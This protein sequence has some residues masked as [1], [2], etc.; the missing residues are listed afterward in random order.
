MRIGFVILASVFLL[1]AVTH[2]QVGDFNGDSIYDCH[3]MELLQAVK[4]AGSN[5][6]RFDLSGDGSVDDRDIDSWLVEANS[7]LG[8]EIYL[9]DVDMDGDVDHRDFNTMAVNHFIRV[10]V[11]TVVSGWCR[12]DYDGDGIVNSAD[13]NEIGSNWLKGVPWDRD[14]PE[15]GNLDRGT[16]VVELPVLPSSLEAWSGDGIV[17]ARTA[18]FDLVAISQRSPRGVLATNVIARMRNDTDEFVS[19]DNVR[20]SGDVHQAWLSVPFGLSQPT[21]KG[22]PVPG[23]AYH[24]DWIRYDSHVLISPSEAGS[25]AGHGYDGIDEINDG[26]DP[27]DQ[28]GALPAASGFPPFLGIGEISS[29]RVTDIFYVV[30]DRPINNLG[31]A[32]AVTPAEI[33]LSGE[34]GEVFLTIGLQGANEEYLPLPD[35]GVVDSVPVPFF[36]RPCDFDRN[37]AC[38]VNELNA[39]IAAIGSDD[40][41]YNL[42]ANPRVNS[43]DVD[44]WL[45]FAGRVD[46]AIVRGDTDLDGDVDASDLNHL[47]L[48]WLIPGEFGWAGGDFDGNGNADSADLNVIGLNWQHGK[49]LVA[50]A[51]PEPHL[52]LRFF[53]ILFLGSV[54]AIHGSKSRSLQGGCDFFAKQSEPFTKPTM[55]G[56]LSS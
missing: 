6:P 48:N 27:T 26:S 19:I 54:R 31:L 21:A 53:A 23:P 32:H 42:D 30:Q 22:E 44:V 45:N 37:G 39:L 2:A 41:T 18:Q 16:A 33:P 9:G 8:Y 51:V 50:P 11:D 1:A 43:D 55:L 38:D 36:A 56:S 10:G 34:L 15:L 14:N 13:R 46:G 7:V 28:A 40:P 47:A 3:D 5:E 49:Q 25:G 4:R 17:F 24:Q 29:R 12:G 20:L 52:P 35:M